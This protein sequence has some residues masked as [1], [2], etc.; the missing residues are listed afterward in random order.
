MSPRQKGWRGKVPEGPVR[1]AH[2]RSAQQEASEARTNRARP[3]SLS[4]EVRDVT[5]TEGG[6]LRASRGLWL[7]RRQRGFNH[8][9]D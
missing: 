3:T 7:S 2:P 9:S 1:P 4:R 8:K 6:G 5:G